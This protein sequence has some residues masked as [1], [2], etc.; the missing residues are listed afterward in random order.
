[1]IHIEALI[2][3]ENT[4]GTMIGVIAVGEKGRIA[5][6]ESRRQGVYINLIL[7]Q[8]KNNTASPKSIMGSEVNREGLQVFLIH[9]DSYLRPCL[10]LI[11]ISYDMS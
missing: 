10:E 7:S 1:M 9:I 2:E 8:K 6:Y 4:G 3:Y 5:T 11:A